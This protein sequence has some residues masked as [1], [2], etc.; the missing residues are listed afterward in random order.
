M[1]EQYGFGDSADLQAVKASLDTGFDVVVF[2]HEHL[3]AFARALRPHTRTPFVSVRHNVSSDAIASILADRPRLAASYRFLAMRQEKRALGGR[4]FDAITAISARDQALLRQLSGRT[5]IGLVLP[6]VPPAAPL[7]PNGAARRDLVVSGTFDWFP[8]ARDLRR[9]AQ[10]YAA[11]PVPGASLFAS[12]TITRDIRDA[13][14]AGDETTLNYGD[15]I[16]FGIVTDRFAAGHKLKTAA[17]LMCN[18]AVVSFAPVLHDFEDMPHARGWIHHVASVADVAGVVDA[19][20]RR[21]APALLAELAA[22][23]A[24]LGTRLAWS[25]QAA[26]LAS[27]MESARAKPVAARP[28]LDERS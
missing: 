17:Y 26:A 16:R 9:F 11:A 28:A 21:P 14:G 19:F 18:C 22:L 8:K 2:S 15:A 24:D 1:P 27:V 23:K 13:L 12:P 20:E 5:D 4:V 25:A 6:G 3:D 10:D 7:P